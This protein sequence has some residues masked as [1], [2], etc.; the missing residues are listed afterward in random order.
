M[1][2]ERGILGF[3]GLSRGDW[4][5]AKLEEEWVVGRKLMYEKAV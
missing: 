3:K 5:S 1:K 4:I 2:E